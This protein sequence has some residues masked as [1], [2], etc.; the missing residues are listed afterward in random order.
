M[1]LR[2]KTMPKTSLP[3]IALVITAVASTSL[4]QTADSTSATDAANSQPTLDQVMNRIVELWNQHKTVSASFLMTGRQNRGGTQ[5][6]VR[7]EG[8]FEYAKDE[9]GSLYRRELR[10]VLRQGVDASDIVLEST[11]LLVDDTESL[12]R[13]TTSSLR[14]GPMATKSQSKPVVAARGGADLFEQLRRQSDLSLLPNETI[15][16]TECYVIETIRRGAPAMIVRAHYYFRKSDGIRLQYV[17]FGPDNLEVQR[18][19]YSDI[20]VNETIDPKRFKFEAPA[21]VRVI[22]RS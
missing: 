20:K 2:V 3:V 9:R 10:T 19:I 7:V 5:M 15:D 17:G 6:S 1:E 12:H 4:A 14:P 22:D 8:A 21:G 18:T 16:G 11:E 13:L